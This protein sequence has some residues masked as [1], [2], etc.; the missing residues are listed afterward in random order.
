MPLLALAKMVLHRMKVVRCHARSHMFGR[1]QLLSQIYGP[2][3]HDSW[4]LTLA[5]CE[6]AAKWIGRAPTVVQNL[7]LGAMPLCFVQPDGI[8]AF[9]S[10]VGNEDLCTGPYSFRCM[11][12]PCSM[13]HQHGGT[14]KPDYFLLFG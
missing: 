5:I 8:I 9:N 7:I 2:C 3:Q 12:F 14:R 10:L 4:A 11:P 6:A 13:V 1:Y